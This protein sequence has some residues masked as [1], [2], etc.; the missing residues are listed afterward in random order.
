MKYY[1]SFIIFVLALIELYSVL[2]PAAPDNARP[3]S[4]WPYLNGVVH[5]HS[6]FS[7]DGGGSIADLMSAAR[8][9]GMDFVVLTDHNSSEA[10]RHGFEHSYSGSDLFV[11]MEVSTPAGHLVTFFSQTPARS[12]PDSKIVDLSWSHLLKR[13][14]TS[15]IFISVAHPSN[16]RTPWTSLDKYSE[17]MEIFN[18]DSV[19]QR[20]LDSSTMDFSITALLFP[21]NRFL[22]AIRLFE[23]YPK[24]LSTWDAMNTIS[25]GHFGVLGHDTHEKLIL[26]KAHHLRWPDYELTFKLASTL[27]IKPDPLPADFEA[28]KRAIYENIRRGRVAVAFQLLYPVAGNDW[29]ISCLGKPPERAGAQVALTKACHFTVTL[30]K[31]FPYTAR[32]RLWKDGLMHQE[33]L[34][35]EEFTNLPVNAPGAYRM[36]VMVPMNTAGKLLWIA[37]CRI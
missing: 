35:R 5:V 34:T 24:D 2:P 19:W 29:F 20:Q 27:V 3:R 16:L 30:P 25:I 9:T 37:M 11:E 13:E 36:E 7:N 15:G 28:R 31:G 21:V 17:G 22:S 8:N 12:L 23:F 26:N 1:L 4:N 10:R 18:F 14:V 6:I 33:V 32:L